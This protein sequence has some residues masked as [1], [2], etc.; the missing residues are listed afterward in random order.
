[1]F[2]VSKAIF[3]GYQFCV[4]EILVEEVVKIDSS[5]HETVITFDKVKVAVRVITGC[6]IVYFK[7]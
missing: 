6:G 1:M 5:S 2:I 4:S 3:E 7:F